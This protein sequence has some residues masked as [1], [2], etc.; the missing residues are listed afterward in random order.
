M[1]RAAAL[2][3][4]L[5]ATAAVTAFADDGP[6]PA[7]SR[8]YPQVT[9]AATNARVQ[10][11][12]L[13]LAEDTRDRLAPVLDLGPTWRFPVQIHVVF[14]DDPAAAQ[15]HEEGVAV[16]AAGKTMTLDVV[17]PSDD[18]EAREFIQGEIVTALVWEKFF[19]NR[20]TFDA[21]TRL[22]VVPLW[23]TEGLR[24]WV[25]EDPDHTREE[26]VRR[27]VQGGRAPKLDEV[28]TW[29]F[30]ADDRLMG[31][32]QRA[33]CYYLV[34]SLV[35][36]GP[37]RDDFQQWL[38]SYAGP[39]PDSAQRLFPTEMGWE[40]QL[41]DATGRGRDVIYTWEETAAE[42]TAA[43]T[44]QI[45][46]KEED[47][48][49]ICTLDTV[50]TFP[51][52]ANL[53]QALQQKINDLTGI[54]LRAHPDWRPILE[55]YRFGLTALMH[56]PKP[57]KARAL[58]ADAR[59]KWIGELAARQQ[60]NDYVNWFEVTQDRSESGSEFE[61]YFRTAQQLDRA[62]KDNPFRASVLQA[63]T[64]L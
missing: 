10:A 38:A 46:A 61:S 40:N 34:A 49:R 44:I 31:L 30:L 13:A 64:N 27:A 17:L 23:L 18:P 19:A 54:E 24:G 4:F 42:L 20:Q 8:L 12:I 62:N 15:V 16:V 51:R 50:A 59:R 60:L 26:I 7:V 39:N 29:Q 48:T 14:P 11:D 5:P 6:L 57:D 47:D 41:A 33:F 21:Q 35:E 37:K 22:D 25:S 55:A 63:E 1:K 58:L 53:V 32:W 9:C 43:E 56:D 2:A 36:K 3:L 52:D 28:T 45:P